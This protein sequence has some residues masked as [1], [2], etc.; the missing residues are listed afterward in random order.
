VGRGGVRLALAILLWVWPGIAGQAAEET[1]RLRV[2]W[3]GDVERQWQG[4][5]A[6]TEGS[7]DS[8]TLLGLEADEA[9]SIWLERGRPEIALL[10]GSKSPKAPPI[11]AADGYLRVRQAGARTYDG[12]DVVVKA[13]LQASL[14]VELRRSDGM[15]QPHPGWIEVRLADVLAKSFST[16]LDDRG[17]RLVVQ[18]SPGDELRVRLPQRSLVFA[19]GETFK[20]EVFPH[21]LPME[22]GSRARLRVQLLPARTSQ[23]LWSAEAVITVGQAGGLT[24]DVPLPKE[25]GAYDVVLAAAQA[26]R[27]ARPGSVLP[28][29]GRRGPVVERTIQVLVLGPK[30]P[31]PPAAEARLTPVE[32]IDP[33][34]PKWWA[35]LAKLSQ[36]ARLQRPSKGPLGNGNSK[37]SQ[38]PLG[39]L[40]QLAPSGRSGEVSWEA[41][42]LPV[43]RPGEPHVLEVDYPSDVPQTLGISVVEPNAAG[44]VVPIG[45]DSGVDHAEEIGTLPAAPRWLRHRL[46]FWPRT[47]APVVL[48]TNRREDAPAVFGK[49]RV[50]SGWQHLPRAFPR[51]EPPPGRLLAAYMDRPL[52]PESFGASEVLGSL[53]DL[54]VDDWITF[55]EAGTRLV[56]YLHHVG[57]NALVLS[58]FADGSTIYPSAAVQPTPRYDTGTFFATAQDPVRK[59]VLE[60]LLR[61][62]DR[63]GLRLIPAVEFATPMAELEAVLRRGGPPAE[64]VAWIGP[65]GTAC[66]QARAPRRGRAPYYNLLHPRVQE[67]MLSV[68]RELAETYGRHG[69]FAGLALQL[70]AD[71]YAQLPG[72]EWGL[73]DVTIALFER[74]SKIELPDTGPDRFARRAAALSTAGAD[75]RREWRREWLEWRSGRLAQFYRR[76]QAELEAVRPGTRLYLAATDLLAGE[77]LARD[78]RP[79]LPRKA[80]TADALLRLGIDVRHYAESDRIVLLRPER[81]APSRPLDGRAID[82]ELGQTPDVDR[83]FQNLAPSGS[84]FFH[85]PQEVRLASF[86]RQSPFKP[87][88]AWLATQP[89]PSAWQNRRRFIHSLATLDA[90]VILDGGWL[91]SMGQ[92]ESL[93]DLIAAYRQLP[94]MRMEKVAPPG[95]STEGQ[96]VTIRAGSAADRTYV[97]LA[98]DAPFPVQVRIQVEASAE[99]RLEALG[100]SSPG[101]APGSLHRGSEGSFWEVPLGPYEL[102]AAAF[103]APGV[104]LTHLSTTW[105]EE[106]ASSLRKQ[107]GELADR[108]ATLGNP[109]LLKVL[110]NGGFERAP[111]ASGAIPGWLPVNPQAVTVRTD[112]ASKHEGSQSLYLAGRGASGGVV[113][114][115]FAAPSTGRLSMLVWLRTSD[116]ARQPPLRLGV[117]WNLGGRTVISSAQ[118]GQAP[119]GH[120]PVKPIPAEWSPFVVHVNDLPMDSRAPMR[121]CFELMGPGEVWIDDVQLSDLVFL[122][123]ERLELLRLIAPAEWKLQ[124]GQVAG[125]IRLLEGYWPRLLAER[126]PLVDSPLTRRE[127]PASPPPEPEPPRSTGFLEKV[128]NLLPER[129]RF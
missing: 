116:P 76:L 66:H 74:D 55:H 44:A 11:L 129:L 96:P 91:L 125:C 4:R 120:A 15:D 27:L 17:S 100:G 69:A 30:T 35:N 103:S 104:R 118:F 63:E 28:Q 40:V 88:Y 117:E 94:A 81:I 9:G 67:T 95:N 77:G 68:V 3:G 26:G 78:L 72:P 113:S 98:N 84:I 97:Y 20:L 99:T 56:E 29:L 65:D 109:P 7:L 41:Y 51:G 2:A 107:I 75:G 33:A 58:V 115:P 124:K 1:M 18:R 127:A 82:L 50:L 48:M 73:D 122:K 102:A 110:E 57:Y 101:S 25:E 8:P 83:C 79:S 121:L 128:R 90:Q 86:D 54:S 10:R 80:T 47:K 34:N 105:P 12:V 37:T 123:E 38:H 32:E 92:E 19:P 89:V 93:R 49:M 5:I 62:F 23:E 52:L 59:D 85:P 16:E 22:P 31:A 119:E 24:W 6:L 64:G 45:L 46:I 126:V 61:M 43:S 36:V 60:M 71:G 13:P 108:A 112:S 39:P 42:S 87:C 106:I 14:L 111:A 114:Q 53:R 21:L 70:S